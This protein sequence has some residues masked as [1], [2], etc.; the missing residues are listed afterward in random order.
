MI[1]L[2]SFLLVGQEIQR[3]A[4]LNYFDA[5]SNPLFNFGYGLTYQ[6]EIFINN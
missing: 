4:N 5:T 2:E 6:E 1:S 3:Q